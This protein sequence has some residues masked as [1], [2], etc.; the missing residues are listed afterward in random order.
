VT[1]DSQGLIKV[2]HMMNLQGGPRPL[3][4]TFQGVAAFAETQRASNTNAGVVRF[5]SAPEDVFGDE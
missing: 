3:G 2:T 4:G 1:V 5:I